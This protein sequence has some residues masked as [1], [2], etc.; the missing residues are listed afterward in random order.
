MASLQGQFLI[1][2]PK[3][4]D[5]NF[6]RSVVLMVQH[7]DEGALGLVVNR[8]LETSVEEVCEK[9]LETPCSTEGVLYQGGAEY[10]DVRRSRAQVSQNRS[11]LEAAQRSVREGVA[12]SWDRLLAARAAIRSFRDEVRAN[13]IALEGVQQEALVGSRTVLD[14]LDAEQELFTSEVNLVRAQRELVVA[15]Y[16]LK[17]AVGELT[18]DDLRLGVETFDPTAYY[19]RNR[20]RLFGLEGGG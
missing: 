20:T 6:A 17:S 14:V 19:Q 1:A 12:S 18:V 9:V 8:P 4:L 10:A 13:R 2:S 15:S 7:G 11:N 5:P 16:Q 3:L